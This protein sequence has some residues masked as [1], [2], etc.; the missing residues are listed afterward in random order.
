MPPQEDLAVGEWRW[1]RLA[2]DGVMRAISIMTPAGLVTLNT[3]PVSTD[4]ERIGG[5]CWG[6]GGAE[7]APTL[8][9]SIMVNRGR[10][11]QWHG[12]LHEGSL[13]EHDTGT[14]VG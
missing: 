3:L 8:S 12:W 10:A 4:D 1:E 7:G 6:R 2:P 14:K 11:D 13:F 5:A 9:P